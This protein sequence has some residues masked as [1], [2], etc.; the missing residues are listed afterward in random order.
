MIL[1]CGSFNLK[2]GNLLFLLSSE[3]IFGNLGLMLMQGLIEEARNVYKYKN[4]VALKTVGYEELF[5]HFED[6][7][8]LDESIRL[9]KRNTRRYAKRQLTWFKRD[10]SVH[11]L[12]PYDLEAITG[13]IDRHYANQ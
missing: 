9:I 11:W 3:N 5:A 12:N 4:M 8:T 10:P 13:L 1:L 6:K 7:I 2:R